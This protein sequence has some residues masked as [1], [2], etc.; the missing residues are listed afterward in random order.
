MDSNYGN[1]VEFLSD[2]YIAADPWKSLILDINQAGCAALGYEREELLGLLVSD[3]LPG[4]GRST[5]TGRTLR[6]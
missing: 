3:V 5:S 4:L 2:M 6:S 1:V